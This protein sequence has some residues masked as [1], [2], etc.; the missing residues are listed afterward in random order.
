MLLERLLMVEKW[1]ISF[2]QSS[3]GNPVVLEWFSKQ[4]AKIQA[5]FARIFDLLEDKGTMVG[6]PYVRPIAGKIYEIRVEQSTNIYRILYFTYTN[7]Q[8]ILLHGF[9][10]K[11]QKTPK[12]EIDLAEK[13][14]KEF[15]SEE[16]FRSKERKNER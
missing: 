5:K 14:R 7:R 15:I 11:T 10:K 6:M 1:K 12:K 9:Q 13:R 4:D 16:A 8:I 2:Y 3:T